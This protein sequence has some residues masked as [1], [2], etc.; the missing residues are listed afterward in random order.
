M[1]GQEPNSTN[2]TDSDSHHTG[3]ISAETIERCAQLLASGEMDWPRDFSDK[4][5]AELLKAVRRCRRARLVRFIASRIA[6]DIA[7]EA[8]SRTTETLL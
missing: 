8:R 4:Q 1:S 2:S 3:Q 7:H 6:A 5:E